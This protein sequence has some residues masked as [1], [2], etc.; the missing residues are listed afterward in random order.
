VELAI[1]NDH[2]RRIT[3]SG[4]HPRA[5]FIIEAMKKSRPLPP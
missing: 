5:S 1:V 2:S 4:R 3:F